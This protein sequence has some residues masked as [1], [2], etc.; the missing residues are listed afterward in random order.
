LTYP[1][2]CNEVFRDPLDGK[3]LASEPTIRQWINGIKSFLDSQGKKSEVFND[4]DLKVEKE[5]DDVKVEL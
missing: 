4:V 5:F 2:L 1:A 3:R